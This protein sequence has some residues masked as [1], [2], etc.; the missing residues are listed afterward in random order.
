MFDHSLSELDAL[1]LIRQIRSLP[2]LNF[3]RLV[4]LTK[5]QREIPP[6]KIAQSHLD[7]VL[8]GPLTQSALIKFMKD[9]LPNFN[10]ALPTLPPLKKRRVSNVAESRAA[11]LPKIAPS[12]GTGQSAVSLDSNSGANVG[13][14]GDAELL[15]EKEVNLESGAN[16]LIN[17]PP[18]AVAAKSNRVILVEENLLTRKITLGLVKSLGYEIDACADFNEVQSLLA[19]TEYGFLIA[20]YEFASTNPVPL[21]KKLHSSH[22]GLRHLALGEITETLL[23]CIQAEEV[24]LHGQLPKPLQR[25]N[26]KAILDCLAMK[27]EG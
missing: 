15:H 13:P 10:P 25:D 6:A 14:G 2:M 17:F 22:P 20:D 4:F 23:D 12:S 27:V 5:N 21:L 7:A 11:K 18:P 24:V 9:L 1:K 3:T 8:K 26:L 16:L 19:K